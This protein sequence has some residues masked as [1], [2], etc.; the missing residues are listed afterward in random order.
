MDSWAWALQVQHRSNNSSITRQP[1]SEASTFSFQEQTNKQIGRSRFT[2]KILSQ[3]LFTN[4]WITFFLFILVFSLQF[5]LP[6]WSHQCFCHSTLLQP[7]PITCILFNNF[8]D[9]VGQLKIECYKLG[10]A[11]SIRKLNLFFFFE[12]LFYFYFQ[13]YPL[14][15]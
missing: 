6:Y 12:Y 10:K 4:L 8:I 5:L 9:K 11:N 3:L 1:W 14:L 13:Y 15:G 7:A 2:P